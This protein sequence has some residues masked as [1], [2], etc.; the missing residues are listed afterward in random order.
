MD[1]V[2]RLRE[3]IVFTYPEIGLLIPLFMHV[4]ECIKVKRQTFVD[5]ARSVN[6]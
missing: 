5:V 3:L 4:V 1:K 6:P 2:D